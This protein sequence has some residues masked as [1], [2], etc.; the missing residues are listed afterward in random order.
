MLLLILGA[1]FFSGI[2]VYCWCKASY[3]ACHKAGQ[4]DNPISLYWLGCIITSVV[5]LM[6]CCFALHVTNGTMVWLLLTISC[7]VGVALSAARQAQKI[8]KKLSQKVI[9]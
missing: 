4:C 1:L 5:S 7:L 3:C 6:L 8:D 9:F 2:S